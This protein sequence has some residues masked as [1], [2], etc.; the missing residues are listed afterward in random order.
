MDN[1]PNGWMYSGITS[2]IDRMK[3]RVCEYC[4]AIDVDLEMHHVR[5]LKDLKKKK[6]LQKWEMIMIARNRRQLALCAR[7]QGNDCHM[8][9]HKGQL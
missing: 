9:L 6:N 4:G 5:K 2:L 1:L 7:G 8:K 3:A